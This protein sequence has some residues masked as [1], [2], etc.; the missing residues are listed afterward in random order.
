VNLRTLTLPSITIPN[1]TIDVQVNVP[2]GSFSP[3]AAVNEFSTNVDLRPTQSLLVGVD[4]KLNAATQILIWTFTSLDPVTALPPLDPFVG[5]LPAGT[6]ASVSFSVT[7]EPGLATGTKISDQATVVFDANAP[8]S[9]PT[10]TNTIDNSPP[11]SEVASLSTI[12]SCPNFKV[13]WSGNDV[14]SGLG[15]FTIYSSDNGGS[16]TPWLSNTTATTGTFVGTVGHTYS[17]YSIAQ[18]LAGNI[19]AAKTS[20][21]TTVQV[22]S[23]TSCTPPSLSAQVL[24]TTQSGATVTVSLQLT[25]T[26]LTTAQSVNINQI[27]ARA[28]SGSGT[29]T[30]SSPTVPAAEGP[31][32]VGASITIP[33]VFSVPDTVTRFSLTESGTLL[34]ANGASYSYSVGQVVI[35]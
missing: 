8:L 14:G 7:P 24:S 20:A 29:V 35:P 32:A 10:W 19:Q 26:G 13:S 34:D 17:F 23:S 5:F 30:L 31:L 3:T 22:T 15:G 2:P 16:F 25:N 27:T 11:T 33:L 1:G 12:A 6:V 21:D 9:T 18:D 28:L 4:V